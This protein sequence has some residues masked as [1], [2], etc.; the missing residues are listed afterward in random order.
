MEEINGTM[1]CSAFNDIGWPSYRVHTILYVYIVVKFTHRANNPNN[2]IKIK[3][4]SSK[5]KTF[6]TDGMTSGRRLSE[7]NPSGCWGVN[8]RNILVIRNVDIC[9]EG[10]EANG[11][12]YKPLGQTLCIK[13]VLSSQCNEY[14]SD[15]N[16]QVDH[17]NDLPFVRDGHVYNGI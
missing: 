8:Q 7:Q 9:Y 14:S 15:G 1:Q 10:Y 3:F 5:P 4:S 17:G 13:P 2:T 16:V 12:P 11:N 6:S